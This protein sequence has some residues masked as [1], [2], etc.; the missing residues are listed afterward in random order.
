MAFRVIIPVHYGSG[1]ME[2]KPLMDLAGK[3][4]IERVYQQCIQS[5]AESIV[6]ATDDH[7]IEEA[8]EK[9]G[10]PV[11]LTSSTHR[12]GTDRLAEAVTI[13]G[14]DKDEVIVNVHGDE[15]MI[16]PVVIH[17]VA[18]KLIEH[19]TIPVATLCEPISKTSTLLNP[20]YVKVV[21]N[22]RGHALY[23]SRAPIAWERDN[24][25]LKE[26]ETFKGPHYRHVGIYAY[27]A[28]F[29]EQYSAWDS[30]ALEEMESLE[31]L[32]VLWHGGRIIVDIAKENIPFGIDT[33]ADLERYRKELLGSSK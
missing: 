10:A 17:Q 6:I 9:F 29:L 8:A 16:P 26:D 22:R 11:C 18:N 21:M 31:Q 2:G 28:G 30:C 4:V 25:P 32:R 7:R 3:S 1:E 20:H 27:R 14:Y 5:G 15:P 12:S 23:F 33:M 24:F 13:L 19:E